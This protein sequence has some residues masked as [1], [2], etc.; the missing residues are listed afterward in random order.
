MRCSFCA[1]TLVC[2][3][4]G[5]WIPESDYDAPGAVVSD[6][7]QEEISDH[8]AEIQSVSQQ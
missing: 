5:M 7:L 1:E 8:L 4:N 6:E 3:M 2:S